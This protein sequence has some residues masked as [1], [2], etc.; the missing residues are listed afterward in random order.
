MLGLMGL[1]FFNTFMN[2]MPQVCHAQD[3]KEQLPR[4]SAIGPEVLLTFQRWEAPYSS[5]HIER[6]H[7]CTSFISRT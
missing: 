4:K 3:V 6:R 1:S 7:P 5:Q 2:L